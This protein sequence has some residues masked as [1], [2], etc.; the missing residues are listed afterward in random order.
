MASF[1]HLAVSAATLGEG[2]S[3]VE[4]VLGHPLGP[5]GKHAAMSTHNRLLGLAGGAYLEVIATDPDA[6][7]PGRPRWFGLDRRA[8][9]PR[10]ATWVARVD[11]LDAAVARMPF[12]GTP[13]TLERG[14]YRWRMA[15]PDDGQPPFGG[16]FPALIAWETDPPA[17]PETGLSLTRLTLRH[18]EAVALRAVLT[19]LIDDRHIAVEEGPRAIEAVIDTQA[20]RRTLT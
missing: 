3:H 16:C 4:A 2:V 12:A 13:L 19:D 7:D 1:D 5:G 14:P 8:G 9:P 10:I 17:F 11:D 15:V 6:P 20:G 18:P